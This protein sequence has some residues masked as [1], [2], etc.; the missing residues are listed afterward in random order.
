MARS[1]NCIF[2]NCVLPGS[3]FSVNFPV[4]SYFSRPEVP[5]SFVGFQ[6]VTLARAERS[7]RGVCP[8]LSL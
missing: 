5:D 4:A 1:A 7:G 6:T 3:E 8:E 2:L